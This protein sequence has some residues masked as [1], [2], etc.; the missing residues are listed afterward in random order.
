MSWKKN[1]REQHMGIYSHVPHEGLMD[2]E[3]SNI[4]RQ[5]STCRSAVLTAMFTPILHVFLLATSK[6]TL[7]PGVRRLLVNHWNVCHLAPLVPGYRTN[8]LLVFLSFLLEDS[9][10]QA[11]G[12]RFLWSFLWLSARFRGESI[13][14]NK[15][16]GI[17]PSLTQPLITPGSSRPG[18]AQP[19]DGFAIK[20]L[21]MECLVT[22]RCV[23][24][25]NL[26]AFALSIQFIVRN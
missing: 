20:P 12:W 14:Y 23:L 22:G 11:H 15:Q 17:S 25:V 8:L 5:T 4:C 2:F 26:W 21:W 19:S 16:T 7:T 9:W 3:C 6:P 10:S 18:H 13:E 24:R 1:G